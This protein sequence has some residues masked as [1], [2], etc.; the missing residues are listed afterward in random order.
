MSK[1]TE[2]TGTEMVNDLSALVYDTDTVPSLEEAKEIL[3]EA[4]IDTSDIKSWA[5]KKLSE[6]QVK[7]KLAE[8]R[9]KRLSLEQRIESMGRSITGPLSELKETVL[10]KIKVLGESDPSGAQIF[11]RKF[12]EVSDDDLEDLDLE[13]NLLNEM[14]GEKETLEDEGSQ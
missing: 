4:K 1:N 5:V 11:A 10:A 3:T 2:K 7:Q 6:V 8:A 12:D 14:E 13:L 9:S